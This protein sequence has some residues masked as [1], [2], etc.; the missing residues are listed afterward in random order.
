M[1]FNLNKIKYK[2]YIIFN[3]NKCPLIYALD[4]ALARLKEQT[5]K[6]I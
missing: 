1:G 2:H 4:A 5:L 6:D 3:I